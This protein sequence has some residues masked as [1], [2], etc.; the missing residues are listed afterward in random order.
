MRN[1]RSSGDRSRTWKKMNDAQLTADEE[2]T[3]QDL[4]NTFTLTISADHQMNKLSP[5]WGQSPQ[6]GS[7][8]YLQKVT[9]DIFGIV[10][11]REESGF[12]Y[13]LNELIG[14][15]NT[16]HTV[17]YIFDRSCINQPLGRIFQ[18]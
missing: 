7:T 8:Y 2:Q 17:S 13:L 10:D 4:K 16:D 3:L 9:Y 14:P 1:I 5:Y 12:V 18:N 11:H 15:K 6:P